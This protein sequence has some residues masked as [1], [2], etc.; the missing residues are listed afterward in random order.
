RHFLRQPVNALLR[1]PRFVTPRIE[2]RFINMTLLQ[3]RRFAFRDVLGDIVLDGGVT[4]SLTPLSCVRQVIIPVG[5]ASLLRGESKAESES[6]IRFVHSPVLLKPPRKGRSIR[7]SY[8][9]I[10]S[11]NKRK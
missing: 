2:E 4:H 5:F 11:K 6:F 7:R 1:Q 8:L 3:K 10:Y 9:T